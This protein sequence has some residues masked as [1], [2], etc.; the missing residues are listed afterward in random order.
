MLR[1]HTRAKLSL[2]DLQFVVAALCKKGEREATLLRLL[3]DAEMRDAM[4]EHPRVLERL[5]ESRQMLAITPFLYFYLLVRAALKE[6]EID[7]REAAEYIANLLV[8]FGKE[9]RAHRVHEQATKEY[10]YLVDLM[11]DL[12]HAGDEEKFYLRSHLGNYSLFLTGLFPAR[13]YHRVKYHPPAPD[14][15]YYESVG[16]KNFRLAAQH[17]C[18]ER[19]QLSETLELL[20]R[21]FKRVRLALNHM[22]E[23]YLHMERNPGGLESVLRRVDQFIAR[24]RGEDEERF[25][26][27]D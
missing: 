19:L 7:D 24:E 26:W 1:R 4:L 25:D 12:L 22:T 5:L 6:F 17:S 15:S 14:F 2:E 13:V 20:G 23:N 16:G 8:E 10:H 27:R 18:A 11:N 3:G 9:S 21:R